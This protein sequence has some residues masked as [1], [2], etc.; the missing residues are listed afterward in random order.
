MSA[1]SWHIVRNK[2]KDTIVTQIISGVCGVTTFTSAAVFMFG[3]IYFSIV[4][5]E[6]NVSILS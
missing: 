1:V 6:N 5:P 3:L 4:S 2:P